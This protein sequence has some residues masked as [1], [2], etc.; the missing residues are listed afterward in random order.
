M[1]IG[2][3]QTPNNH[4]GDKNKLY[5][6]ED[7]VKYKNSDNSVNLNNIPKNSKNI[8]GFDVEY[9]RKNHIYE[10]SNW[11]QFKNYVRAKK[12][13]AL[14]GSRNIKLDRRLKDIQNERNKIDVSTLSML[15]SEGSVI[16]GDHFYDIK[17]GKILKYNKSNQKLLDE[18]KIELEPMKQKVQKNSSKSLRKGASDIAY[19]SRV[20]IYSEIK[21]ESLESRAYAYNESYTTWTGYSKSRA[22]TAVQV[23]NNGW[24]DATDAVFS[25]YDLKV[26]AVSKSRGWGF[27][28]CEE[29]TE[30][31][32]DNSSGSAYA[33]KDR[34]DGTGTKSRNHEASANGIDFYWP[35]GKTTYSLP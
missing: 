9:V 6:K 17:D 22:I 25:S 15:S 13:I 8:K 26:T 28:D 4:I 33:G 27:W 18:Y 16:I 3:D 14:S 31:D 19:S 32:T 10:F 11:D 30:T 21:Q 24:V 1:I 2:C 23:Y 5:N 35:N 12:A 7:V 29:T 34:C 20:Y